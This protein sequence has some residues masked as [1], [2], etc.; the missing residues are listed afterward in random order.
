VRHEERYQKLA[1]RGK[2]VRT[3]RAAVMSQVRESR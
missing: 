3:T 1:S 2:N